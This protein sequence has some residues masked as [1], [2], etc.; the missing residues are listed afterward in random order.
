MTA[1]LDDRVAAF[2]ADHP[3]L[4]ARE[5]ARGV[6]ARYQAVRDLLEQP[7]YE[8][9][10][11][12]AHGADRALVYRLVG[13]PAGARP[14]TLGDV[15]VALPGSQVDRI[16]AVLADGEWHTTSAIH[17]VVGFCRLNSRVAELRARLTVYG[18][19]IECRHVAGA[20]KGADAYEYRLARIAESEAA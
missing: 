17:R 11:R 13:S 6:H 15:A 19:T 14:E 16:A 4:T 12:G 3:G 10:S 5:I 7:I 20:A 9:A 2:V 18:K 8:T 1:R